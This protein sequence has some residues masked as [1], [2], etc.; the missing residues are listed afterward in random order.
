MILRQVQNDSLLLSSKQ[1]ILLCPL[2][3]GF[4][5][6]DWPH[7]S[8]LIDVGYSTYNRLRT[9][10]D[11]RVQAL[12]GISKG[13]QWNARPITSCFSESNRNSGHA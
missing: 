6:N 1:M 8:A 10:K 12:G 2:V 3:P 9:T 13:T 7:G 4:P 5:E 11:N